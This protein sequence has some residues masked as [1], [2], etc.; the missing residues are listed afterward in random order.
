MP[1]SKENSMQD[2]AGHEKKIVSG[3]V[4]CGSQTAKVEEYILLCGTTL[5][6]YPQ[7]LTAIAQ[8]KKACAMTNKRIQALDARKA[9]AIMSACDEMIAGLFADQFSLCAVGGFGTPLN[10]ATNE[11]LA[12]R[13]TE[14]LIK[15]KSSSYYVCPN[16]DVNMGQS[17][18]DV[19]KTAKILAVYDAVGV[20]LGYFPYLETPLMD[21]AYELKDVVKVGRTSYQDTVPVTLGQEFSGY[22]SQIKRNKLRLEKERERW[23]RVPLGATFIGTGLGCKPGYFDT[24]C[25]N[26]S[27]VCG[28]KIVQD[29]NLFDAMQ[30][31]D[32]YVLLHAHIQSL[33]ICASKM[34]LDIRLMASGPR[35]GLREITL[36]ALQQGSSIMPGKINPVIPHMVSQ[37]SQ[38]ISANHAGIA[39]AASSGELDLG[40]TSSVIFKNLFD[41]ME[42]MGKGMKIFGEKVVSCVTPYTERCR[43]LAEQSLGLSPVISV[44]FGYEKGKKVAEL[45]REKNITCKEA[46]LQE[47]LLS[48]AVADEIFDV[49]SLTDVHRSEKLF[50]KHMRKSA[51]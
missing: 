6:S 51:Q 17:S 11:M 20:L 9:D 22:H 23:N 38:R 15:D 5:A 8:V 28:R 30:S 43:D 46:A 34:A 24:V 50:E 45:A 14:L 21:K 32:T 7:I 13:A 47:G 39:F 29:E 33:A 41:S 44:L 49:L 48:R 1:R 3:G 36:K 25:D 26:L 42:L 27:T 18:H 31:S 19:I 40:S 10:I 35:A 2:I 4:Y 37:I 12:K 16:D